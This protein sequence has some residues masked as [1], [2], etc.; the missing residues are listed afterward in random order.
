MTDIL[1]RIDASSVNEGAHD[2]LC[3]LPVGWAHRYSGNGPLHCL[4]DNEI[5]AQN[6]AATVGGSAHVVA[7]YDEETLDAGVA[8]ESD[9]LRMAEAA[10]MALVMSHEGRIE[11]LTDAISYA[12]HQLEQARIWN[13]MG[14]HYNP[15]SPM[16]YQPALQRLREVLG[17]N[18]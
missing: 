12:A 2:L 6:D 5:D 3:R 13:G 8:A 9:R 15:L 11:R 14:W 10:A 16:F 7:L 4:R 1:D 17:H 18:V